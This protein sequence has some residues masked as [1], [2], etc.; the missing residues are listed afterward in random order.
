[1]IKRSDF[2]PVKYSQYVDRQLMELSGDAAIGWSI[3]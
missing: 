2:V 1:M 3:Q